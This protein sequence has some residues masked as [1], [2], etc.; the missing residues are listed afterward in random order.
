MHILKKWIVL[1]WNIRGLN[2]KSKQLALLNAINT[3]ACSV[4]CLQE[5]KKCHFD[6]EFIKSCCPRRFDD[7]VYIPSTGA[8]GG[9]IIIW[10]SS[11]FSGM[12]MHCEPFAISVHFTSTQSAQS[13]TLVNIYGPCDGDLR[14]SFI[15]WL[16]QLNIPS[17]EDWLIVG[18]FNFIR[19]LANRNKPGGNVNDMLIFNDFI[20]SQNLTELPI[21]GRKYTWSNMQ[22][23]PLLE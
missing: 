9:L 18:D 16:F 4:V 8:S 22:N 1:C 6:I 21:K 2:D 12:I 3:S 20:R 7:F 19:S 23:D 15:Q 14:N 11:V 17:E 5:T 10:D 13:W